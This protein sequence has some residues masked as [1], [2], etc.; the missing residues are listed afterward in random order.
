VGSTTTL[1]ASTTSS[2][3]ASTTP[4]PAQAQGLTFARQPVNRPPDRSELTRLLRIRAFAARAALNHP[5]PPFYP[6]LPTS[7]TPP[8]TALETAYPQLSQ[9]STAV[10]TQG[11]QPEPE[12]EDEGELPSPL[13]VPK[14]PLCSG[15][16]Y[17]GRCFQNRC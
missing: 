14:V 2:P 10:A 13:F 5:G 1:V 9:A 16:A 12:E 8:P 3:A 17:M 15:T 11:S 6:I 4:A 7:P